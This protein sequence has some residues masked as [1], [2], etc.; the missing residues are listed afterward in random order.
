[1]YGLA[2]SIAGIFGPPVGGLLFDTRLLNVTIDENEEY[3]HNESL[4]SHPFLAVFGLGA[5]IFLLSL[6]LTSTCLLDS[7]PH[8]SESIQL[9]LRQSIDEAP[10]IRHNSVEIHQTNSHKRKRVLTN[11]SASN[12]S[13]SGFSIFKHPA[14]LPI[15]LYCMIAMTNMLYQSKI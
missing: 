4:S 10:E 6:I 9:E 2:H 13:N 1:M 11:I 5:F 3:S 12:P 14:I 15:V 8:N 7:R